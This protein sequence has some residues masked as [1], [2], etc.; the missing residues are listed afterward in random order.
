MR[1]ETVE[2]QVF[3]AV[4]RLRK[5]PLFQISTVSL[6]QTSGD[7]CRFEGKHAL[8]LGDDLGDRWNV[9]ILTEIEV[10]V[11]HYPSSCALNEFT[12]YGDHLWIFD[13]DGLCQLIQ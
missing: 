1:K 9:V 10:L 13:A 7:V 11:P 12:R 8:C 2:K 3:E 4:I 5:I 6:L